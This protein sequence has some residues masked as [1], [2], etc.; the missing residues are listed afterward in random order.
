M[1]V[2]ALFRWLS[3]KY[4]KLVT[5]VI[6]EQ[7]VQVPGPDG[8]VEF[9]P[10]D[11]S[12]PNPNGEEFDNLYLDMN[13]IVHPCTHPEGKPAPK[14]E[15]DMMREVFIY[16]D[17]VVSMVRPRKLLMMAIDGVAPRAKMNQQRSRRF[18]SAQEAK[19]KEEDRQNAIKELEAMG[20]EVSDEYRN[21][22]GWDSNAITPGTPFMDLLAKSLRYWVRKKINEDPGW[23][24]LEVIISDASVPGEGEHKIMD[25]IRRQRVSPDHDPNTKHV[26]YGLDAD[27]IMLSLATH[28]PHFKV[29]REDVFADEKKKGRGCHRCGQPGHHSSQCTG[30]VKKPE[31]DLTP[32]GAP[33]SLKPFIFL[34]VAT[35]REYLAVELS[36][37]IHTFPFNLERAID[38][39][40]FLIFFVGNDFLP[41]L[42][43]LE[44]REGAIDTLIG[45][46][47][48]SLERMGGYLTNHGKVELKRVQIIF[49]Q[50]AMREDEIFRKR[51][52]AEERQDR[53]EKRRKIERE[54]RDQHRNGG[55]GGNHMRFPEPT[56]APEQ[57]YVEVNANG[58][59]AVTASGPAGLPAKP[60]WAADAAA[61]SEEKEADKGKEAASLVGSNK[62]IVANRM[63]IRMA[64][65]SAA[66]MLKAEL[67]AG[68]SSS[69]AKTETPA[70][71]EDDA[72]VKKEK[73]AEEAGKAEAER[74]SA[75]AAK[76]KAEMLASSEDQMADEATSPRGTKR[77]APPDDGVGSQDPDDALD[78][79]VDED[80]EE[81]AD[82]VNAFLKS[83][84]LPPKPA[85]VAGLGIAEPPPLKMLGNNV[86]EQ[87]DTVKLWE[88]GYKERYYRSKFGVE[89][90]DVEFRKKI[91]KCYV[92]GLCWVLHYYYQ[93]TPSWQ[94]YYPYHFSPFASDFVDI[95]QLEIDFELGAPFRPYEQLMGVFPA[96]SRIHL[97]E[98]FQPLMTESDSPI[99]D[100]Y[101]E[102]FHIDMNGKKMLWQGVALLPFIDEKRLLDAMAGKYPHLS[103]FEI[104]RNERGKD[105]ILVGNK[106]PLY[107]YIEG[108]YGKKKAKEPVPL[109]AKRSK[110]IAGAVLPDDTVPGTTFDS[111]LPSMPD[112]V[113]DES[114]S[115][116]FFFPPQT[117]PHRSVLLPGAKLERS[118]LTPYDKDQV[119]RGA[120]ERTES[121]GFHAMRQRDQGGPGFAKVD[122]V[123]RGTP[124]GRGGYQGGTNSSYGGGGGGGGGYASGYNT[125]GG[126]SSGAQTPQG[127]YAGY[128]YGQGGGGGAYGGYAGYNAGA[129]PPAASYGGA[130]GYAL[131]TGYIAPPLP[132]GYR[133]P[134]PPPAPYYPQ[135]TQQGPGGARYPQQPPSYP[136]YSQ[137]GGAGGYGGYGGQG[138]Y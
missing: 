66:D 91:V 105:V 24:G 119:R 124:Q 33:G 4:P 97:P 52:E 28:E 46:W 58:T 15:E 133:P 126:Y 116:Y 94:W 27:L 118:N 31:A 48:N 127:A 29:L 38:D 135:Q 26:I 107:D 10:V 123:G 55:G 111:P 1:G 103:D 78:P 88:P 106:H 117:Q 83:S 37:P 42:P 90:S 121:N 61:K 137:Y 86:V 8:E 71:E 101:P 16:T 130:A 74:N 2:P 60:Q 98:P 82:G 63:A 132:S 19:Q 96:A 72:E 34:D 43:S 23:A 62:S 77:A 6:E 7:P 75:A 36:A 95:D 21:E 54:Q 41:H 25:F 13:G 59:V 136:P 67:A 99:I 14:T 49:E 138:R 79:E 110:G 9:L 114:I 3:K 57:D 56:A 81:D 113:N 125:P 39:W 109:V 20:K 69:D 85:M 84:L 51:R 87:D 92:E 12:G 104:Q 53:A 89:L 35:L 129:R 50:L 93:G 18:R 30:E 17:R 45:I 32:K 102:E 65:L 73:E 108:L 128:G 11:S 134:P 80:D 44:I 68:S 100:F 112:I 120:G 47:K 40:V 5:S 70:A 22:K 115:A 131:P 122:R 76:L 64:N